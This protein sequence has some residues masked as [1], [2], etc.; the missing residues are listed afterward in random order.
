MINAAGDR[1]S[2]KST[3]AIRLAAKEDAVLVVA[4]Q[5]IAKHHISKAKELGLTIRQPILHRDFLSGFSSKMAGQS[6]VKYV[7]DD[8]EFILQQLAW[9]IG[10]VVGATMTAGHLTQKE[11]DSQYQT[12]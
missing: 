8:A 11:N 12:I 9:P 6:N 3:W 1:Q 5:N 10:E 2:G 7:I 4:N